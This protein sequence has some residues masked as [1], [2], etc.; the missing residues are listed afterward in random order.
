[1]IQKTLGLSDVP[2]FLPEPLADEVIQYIREQNWC[3]QLFRS[4]HMPS[5][6]FDIPKVTDGFDAYYGS[7]GESAQETSL[8]T[9][10][11]Q[12][13]AKKL[14]AACT[15]DTE[16]FEDSQPNVRALVMEEFAKAAAEAEEKAMVQG[17]VDHTPTTSTLASATTTTWYT[18]DSRLAFDGLFTIAADTASGAP[19]AL[20]ASS[21]DMSFALLNEAIY[22]LGKYGTNRSNLVLLVN[23][24][25]AMKL[26]ADDKVVTVDKFGPN[27]PVK[28]GYL[29]NMLGVDIVE[30]AYA[31]DGEAVLT[32]KDNPRIGDRRL[33]KVA[34]DVDVRTDQTILVVSERL[35][36][37]V[38]R[39]AACLLIDNLS[40]DSSS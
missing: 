9:S 27:A 38:M 1:M 25:A 23:R 18:K 14:F 2:D 16:V 40:E 22:K 6:T 5:R 12:Y 32:T 17:D 11:V 35:D 36:F 33:I 39:Y 30:T 37:H 19:S 31:N 8:S 21:A 15:I 29:G 10:T 4:F 24:Y 13:I 20:D 28:T 34:Q 26:R 7:A 3:R